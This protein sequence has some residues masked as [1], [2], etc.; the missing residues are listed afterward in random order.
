MIGIAG[1]LS[2]S[3]LADRSTAALLVEAVEQGWWYSALLPDD[4]LIAVFM[5]DS[6]LVLGGSV[7]P[8]L[9]WTEHHRRA[10]HT[11]KRASGFGLP[12]KVQIRSAS[13][14]RLK[15]V[16]GHNWLALAEAA[17]GYNPLS[18]MGLIRALQSALIAAQTICE[19][20]S[21]DGGA[22][23]R[24]EAQLQAEFETYLSQRAAY[25]GRVDRWPNSEFWRRRQLAKS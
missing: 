14:Y 18:S 23:K 22:L 16:C 3:S 19:H 10:F 2:P 1:W 6:D 8:Q 20:L 13:S 17:A 25:Y 4:R 9:F 12:T 21:G 24:Y 11:R 5:S 7:R 15:Q